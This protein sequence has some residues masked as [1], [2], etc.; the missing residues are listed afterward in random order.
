MTT[1]GFPPIEDMN[2]AE[3]ASE[4]E[5]ELRLLTSMLPTDHTW[6]TLTPEKRRQWFAA[7]EHVTSRSPILSKLP[8]TDRVAVALTGFSLGHNYALEYGALWRKPVRPEVR[9]DD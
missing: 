8:T 7:L 5:I 6:N 2:T 3:W 4:R 9:R 1:D